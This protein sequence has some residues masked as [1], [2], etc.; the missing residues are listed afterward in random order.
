MLSKKMSLAR[1]IVSGGL[2]PVEALLDLVINEPLIYHVD[3]GPKE[4]VSRLFVS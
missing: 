1:N 2:R 4:M 3:V